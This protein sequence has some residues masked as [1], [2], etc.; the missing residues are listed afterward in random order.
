MDFLVYPCVQNL[1][2]DPMNHRS[3]QHDHAD[4]VQLNVHDLGF[5]HLLLL[6]GHKFEEFIYFYKLSIF[7]IQ[8]I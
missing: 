3:N 6:L 1:H 4:V 8:S 7:A 2:V 5:F